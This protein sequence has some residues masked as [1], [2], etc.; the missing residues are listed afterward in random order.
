MLWALRRYTT[1]RLNV[2]T[3]RLHTVPLMVLMPHGGCNARCLM[4][5]IWKANAE[6]RTLSVDQIRS[7][8]PD[9]KRLGTERVVLSGGEALM[10]PNLFT[11]TQL[12]RD[13]GIRITLL[14]TGLSLERCADQVAEQIDEVTVSLDGTPALHDQIRNIPRAYER[15]AAGVRAVRSKSAKVRITGRTV[16]QRIN[17]RALPEIID[18]ARAAGLDQISFLPVDASSQAFNRL[19]VWSDDRSQDVVIP[20]AELDDLHTVLEETLA[21]HF[22]DFASGFVAES[23]A[24]WRNIGQYFSAIHRRAEFPR[25][26]CNAPWVSAVIE[27]DGAVRPCFF[28]PAYGSLEGGAVEAVLNAKAAIDYR[29]ALDVEAEPTCQRCVCTLSIGPGHPL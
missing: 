26:N 3:D 19:V 27:S 5:D 11:M 24:K 1:R 22:G 4:C 8:L 21:S 23:P 10:H 16:V 9:L 12:L 25:V 7:L 13:L 18:T 28:L 2:L 14:S 17:F 20:E 15:L 29:K 6:A